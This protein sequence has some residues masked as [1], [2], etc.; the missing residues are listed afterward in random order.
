MCAT[1]VIFDQYGPWIPTP[2]QQWPQRP[3]DPAPY[4]NGELRE[5]IDSFKEALEAAKKFDRL[6][7]Q[8]DCEDPDKAKL[9]DRV[10]ELERR[11]DAIENAS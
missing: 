6:T 9:L 7:N 11:L 10:V 5:L 1:S 8:P 2:Q 3:I 4:S